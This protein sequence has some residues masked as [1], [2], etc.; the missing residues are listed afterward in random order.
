MRILLKRA[1][2]VLTFTI[3]VILCGWFIYNQIWPTEEFKSG[4]RS[5]FQLG[6]PIAC[7]V[8][9][10]KWMCYKG[11]G[12]EEVVPPD[13]KCPELDIALEKAKSSLPLF[14]EE[15]EKGI[16]GAYIKFPLKTPRGFTGHIWA[17]VHFYKENRFNVSLVNT[18][19]DEDQLSE[20]RRDV[21]LDDVEDWQIMSPD[22]S[23]QGAFSLI[24]LFEYWEG[25]GNRL[26]PLMKIQKSLLRAV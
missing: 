6:F 3:G 13:F 17:Y 15:V 4:F 2:G 12:I 16:D 1:F 19:S 24:A 18:P 22:G 5:V 23:I 25:A 21:P 11:K 7:L 20:G 26:T 14:I 8:M 10:W 9:G